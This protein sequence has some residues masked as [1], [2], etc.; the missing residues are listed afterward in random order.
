MRRRK[1][2]GREE[3]STCPYPEVRRVEVA[4][5]NGESEHRRLGEGEEIAG[6]EEEGEERRR[7]RSEIG[8]CAGT[9]VVVCRCGDV[10]V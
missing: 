1:R 2:R 4:R 5:S 8:R 9:G 6:E 10:I 7:R 3:R